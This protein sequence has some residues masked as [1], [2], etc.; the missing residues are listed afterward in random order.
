MVKGKSGG[1]RKQCQKILPKVK[2]ETRAAKV[3]RCKMPLN[4]KLQCPVHGK[5]IGD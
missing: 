5:D 2:P 3:A 4:S 1:S